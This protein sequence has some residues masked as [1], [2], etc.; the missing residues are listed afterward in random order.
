MLNAIAAKYEGADHAITNPEAI[1][2]IAAVADNIGSKPTGTKT[3]TENGT[4]DIAAF[5]NAE[6]NVLPEKFEIIIYNLSSRVINA[7]TVNQYNI[8]FFRRL[9]ATGTD[10]NAVVIDG[11]ATFFIEVKS[12]SQ[13]FSYQIVKRNDPTDETGFTVE[14][15]GDS[16]LI[17][18]TIDCSLVESGLEVNIN[19]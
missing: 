5:A 12:G 15:M 17:R 19:S 9:K 16:D 2:N 11:K 8:S 4:H 6:V 10:V 13:L 7:S 1:A 14:G 18:I 3:I